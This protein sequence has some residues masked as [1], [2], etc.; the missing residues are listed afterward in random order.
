LDLFD[1]VLNLPSRLEE[2]LSPLVFCENAG[3]AKTMI[4]SRPMILKIAENAR[5]LL[6]SLG[7]KK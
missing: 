5:V 3:T 1:G 2:G 6:L 7:F 4:N